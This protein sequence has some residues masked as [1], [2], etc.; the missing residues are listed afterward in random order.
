MNNELMALDVEQISLQQGNINFPEYTKLKQQAQELAEWISNIE[1]QPENVKENKKLLAAVNK[2][3]NEL[4]T[5]RK[6]IKACMLEPYNQFEQQVKEIV[7]IV[8]DA[9]EIV[10]QQ[11]KALEEQ[12]RQ[13]KKAA[14]EDLFN[15]RIVH[16]SFRDLFTFDDFLKP[17]HLNKTASIDS[18]EKEIISFLSKITADLKAIES[19]PD[20]KEVLSAYLDTK[21][22]AGALTLYQKNKQQKERIEQAQALQ[23]TES[24]I[25][26]LVSV[27]VYNQKELKLLEMLLQ[28]N[29]F[30]FMTDKITGGN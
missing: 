24:E 7:A 12:E 9:D 18:V 13:E 29:G 17:Q 25:N 30:E 16:Y 26:Y 11:V 20:A 23:P 21:D 28:Q 10:R 5:R 22:L 8:K 1:V 2:S 19:M 15:K 6:A 3:V 4:E 27:K 14:L